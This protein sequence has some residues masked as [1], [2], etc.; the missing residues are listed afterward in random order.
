MRTVEGG[1][2]GCTQPATS[3]PFRSTPQSTQVRAW[4]V[5]CVFG[6]CRLHGRIG[7][8]C[9]PTAASHSV[10]FCNLWRR[11][12]RWPCAARRCGGGSGS[13]NVMW[14]WECLTQC[15][16]FFVFIAQ[17]TAVAL[18]CEAMWWWEW[19]SRTCHTLTTSGTSSRCLWCD[20]SSG[21][22]CNV[23]C[24][25]HSLLYFVLR[26]H[27]EPAACCVAQHGS[28]CA[29]QFAS[30]YQSDPLRYQSDP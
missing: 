12:Q 14:W 21:A 26:L 1:R 22:L 18:R 13:H 30:R 7:Y 20:A 23:L 10:L 8:T 28:T 19:P 24:V 25:L 4:W 6:T 15:P 17:A 5:G 2:G 27:T 3:W 11:Q 9:S 29:H 16:A